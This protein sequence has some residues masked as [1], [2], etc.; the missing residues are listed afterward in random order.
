MTQKKIVLFMKGNRNVPKCGF[1]RTMVGLL[2]EKGVEDYATFDIL[3]DD[4]VRQGE[5]LQFALIRGA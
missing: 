5:H 3:T 2:K 4:S 1:S